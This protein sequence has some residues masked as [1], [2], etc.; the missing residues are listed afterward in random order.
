ML[1]ETPLPFEFK[2]PEREAVPLLFNSPHSGRFYPQ[3]FLAASRLDDHAIRQSEDMFVDELLADAPHIGVAV[4][5][6]HYPRAYVDLNRAPYELEQNLFAE[7]LP[8]HIDRHSARA[9]AGLGTVPRLVAENTPIY[10]KKL[11]FAEAERR[12]ETIYHPFH[13]RLADEMTRMHS[14]HGYA[15]LIDTHSMPSQATR[16]SADDP[17][18]DFVI[19]DRHGRSCAPQLSDWIAAFLDARGWRVN[20]NKPYAGGFITSRYGKPGEGHHAV[21][22]EINRALYMDESGY[23]KHAGFQELQTQLSDMTRELIELLPAMLGHQGSSRSA[24]E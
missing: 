3:E 13:R 19:G 22:I 12:I 15:V 1:R 11:D 7:P 6:A 21:Q 4:M 24:A 10:D 8:P 23:E 14:L 18:V 5:S 16:L 17:Q 9:A 2:S 20:R